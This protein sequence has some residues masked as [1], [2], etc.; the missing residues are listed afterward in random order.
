MIESDYAI[1]EELYLGPVTRVARC[2]GRD[3]RGSVIVK[4]VTHAAYSLTQHARLVAEYKALVAQEVAGIP[5][6]PKPL[7]LIDRPG[8]VAVVTNDV[9]AQALRLQKSKLGLE[10]MV[11]IGVRVACALG[12]MHQ[13]RWLHKDINPGNIVYNAETHAV[14]VIDFGIAARTAQELHELSTP[15]NMEGTLPYMAPEQ[16]GRTSR[17]ADHRSDFYSLGATLYELLTGERLF[18][19]D[20]NLQLLYAILATP[21]PDVRLHLSACPAPLAMIVA[22]LL[23]KAP[24]ARYQSAF[25]LIH[26]LQRALHTRPFALGTQE[27]NERFDIPAKLYGREPALEILRATY[28]QAVNVQ[29]ALLLVRGPSGI[30]KS[31]LVHALRRDPVAQTAL[32]AE[33]KFDPLRRHVPFSGFSM[34][35]ASLTRRLLQ[36]PE[37]ALTVWRRRMQEAIGTV[38]QALVEVAPAL[39]L[40][41]GRQPTLP[42]LPPQQNENRL[43]WLLQRFVQ[44]L[45]S[46]EPL[47]LFVDD[48]QWADNASLKLLHLLTANSSKGLLL[49]AAYREEDVTSGHPLADAIA[50]INGQ[51]RSAEQADLP[52]LDVPPMRSNEVSQLLQDATHATAEATGPL[53]ERVLAKT[54]GNPFFVR[55]CLRD[56]HARRLLHYDLLAGIWTWDLAQIDSAPVTS[57]VVTLLTETLQAL[58]QAQRRTL[59]LAACLGNTFVAGALA[60]LLEIDIDAVLPLLGVAQQAG[61]VVALRGDLRY[62]EVARAEFQFCHGQVQEV[63]YAM[64]PVEERQAVHLRIGMRLW[65]QRRHE[66][67]HLWVFEALE[68]LNKAAPLVTVEHARLE[69]A[70]LNLLA[71]REAKRSAAYAGALVYL[72]HG[73]PLLPAHAWQQYYA[74]RRDFNLEMAECSYLAGDALDATPYLDEGLMRVQL[75]EERAELHRRRLLCMTT[76]RRDR[77]ALD[78][79]VAALAE[80]GFAVPRQPGL[81]HLARWQARL[82]WALRGKDI[83]NLAALPEAT[84]PTL[85]R[86]AQILAEMH[87]PASHCHARLATLVTLMSGVLNMESGNTPTAAF[88][89][90]SLAAAFEARG[91]VAQARAFALAARRR[92]AACSGPLDHRSELVA[93]RFSEFLTAP[94]Y[95]VVEGFLHAGAAAQDQGDML[96]AGLGPMLAAMLLSSVQVDQTVELVQRHIGWYETREG[97]TGAIMDSVLQYCRCLRGETV[98]AADWTDAGAQPMFKHEA[99]ETVMQVMPANTAASYYKLRTEAA[100]VFGDFATVLACGRR[101]HALG[102]FEDTAGAAPAVIAFYVCLA[103]LRRARARPN[104]ALEERALLRK[105]R[106]LVR[107]LARGAS[108]MWGGLGALLNAEAAAL[109]GNTLQALSLYETCLP[110]LEA[111]GYVSYSAVAYESAGIFLLECGMYVAAEAHL[112]RAQVLFSRWGAK[113]KTHA[114]AH[115]HA[116]FKADAAAHAAPAAGQQVSS[117]V[118]DASSA[119][120]R[121]DGD[122][123]WTLTEALMGEARLFALIEQ[124]MET[125]R[126]ITGATRGALL[127]K[128]GTRMQVQHDSAGA[129]A[130]LPQDLLQYVTRTQEPVMLDNVLHHGT[131][132]RDPYWRN[133]AAHAVMCVPLLH[134]GQLRGVVYLENDQTSN[135]FTP[136]RLQ[137]A[138][139]MAAQAAILLE[140]AA[141]QGDFERAVRER[142]LSVVGDHSQTVAQEREAAGMQIAGGFAHEMRNALS[143]ALYSLGATFDP[144][145]GAFHAHEADMLRVQAQLAQLDGPGTQDL[146]GRLTEQ[147]GM[148]REILDQVYRS[149]Q[150]G[151]ALT[152]Q[153]L[154]YAHAAQI[155]PGDHA[156]EVQP[157]LDS[158]LQEMRAD[159][160]QQHID[161][162]IEVDVAAQG[163]LRL[164]MQ[165]AHAM[166]ILRHLLSNARDALQ[167]RPGDFDK[168]IVVRASRSEDHV[169]VSVVDNGVGIAP[170][171]SNRV[172]QP[173]FSTKGSQGRGLGLGISRKLAQVYG[174]Y[175]DFESEPER[176][177][178]F[179]VLL[180]HRPDARST[181]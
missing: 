21:A 53:A 31:A 171:L 3:G 79:G 91:Q 68:H 10:A 76:L 137:A 4:T 123:L 156:T 70:A 30:G 114:L 113:G 173:F 136:A 26:D 107:S 65:Q 152:E 122:A 155:L 38:G 44:T 118:S 47:I 75:P 29:S 48:M 11:E 157:L 151:L 140:N 134:R 69:L 144:L 18:E 94:P 102:F 23:E 12:A 120:S 13:A 99:W 86:V 165:Q 164:P 128:Q 87:H 153:A 100:A 59:S 9:G 146:R 139:V 121:L 148:S 14:Q 56:L 108:P 105:G 169:M 158:L 131:F 176:G 88:A 141:L 60:D 181:R 2:R 51:R 46:R 161:I 104:K 61:L 98:S 150:R 39:E 117:E 71:A 168:H 27:R 90:A 50:R 172:F 85:L 142:T 37:E 62:G 77:E 83:A 154:Q 42:E 174:G 162:A 119:G 130:S 133:R 145:D 35:L 52:A 84:D 1:L 66:A 17:P 63:A 40:L 45:S 82:R 28:L 19:Y 101:A 96:Y 125:V 34:A 58:P 132:S 24:E 159:L 111:A 138:R 95:E 166:T 97:E 5:H 25:G 81:R 116:F 57:N 80:L 106:R 73:L 124:L 149:V 15:R 103:I 180:P 6:V 32:F 72:A 115:V 143:P 55:Q 67:A 163:S 179:S 92:R 175:I 147:M 49:V 178:T 20:D 126:D 74:V 160:Q 7:E 110:V 41:V 43:V 54:A 127:L 8:R 16:T 177:S 64:L 112:R 129:L 135:S 93:L 78:A 167:Q 22:K 170:A 33:G 109:R 89:Y 36:L